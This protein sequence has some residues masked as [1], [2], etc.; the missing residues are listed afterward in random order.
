MPLVP[1]HIQNLISYKPG[2]T[3][4]ELKREY[5]LDFVIKLAS[6]E[7]PEG[8]SPMALTA[9]LDTLNENFRYPDAFSFELRQKL[10]ERYKLKIENV[11]VGA[12]S[13]GIIST[14][15]RTFLRLS[16]EIIAADN[17]FIGFRV[18]FLIFFC[19]KAF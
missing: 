13:E 3:I 12:G 5:G 4:G 16:D 18:M 6:N 11:T 17:S 2:K 10:A 9:V 7:N 14:I 8:A 1:L 19:A 15:M